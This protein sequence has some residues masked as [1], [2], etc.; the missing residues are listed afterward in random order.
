MGLEYVG[1]HFL[2]RK[3]DI[4]LSMSCQ[5]V[6]PMASGHVCLLHAPQGAVLERESRKGQGLCSLE[7]AGLGGDSPGVEPQPGTEPGEGQAA[8]KKETKVPRREL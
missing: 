1:D 7:G 5:P 6:K 8:R 4:C 2:P 3:F